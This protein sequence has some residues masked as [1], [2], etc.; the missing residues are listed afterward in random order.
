[1]TGVQALDMGIKYLFLEWA[2]GTGKSTILGW[3]VK[4]AARQLPR[5]T[6]VL[7]GQTY[8]QM[9]A[10]TLPSTKEGL[11]MFG[12]HEGI[13]YVVGRH[14]KKLGFEMPYQA[15][16]KWDNVIHF[17]NGFILVLVSLDNPNSGRGLNSYIV[18]GDEA[19]LLDPE[20]LFNNVQTTNRASK[21]W[22]EKSKLLNAEIFATSTPMTK[23]GK[24]FTS[25]EKKIL[26]AIKGISNEITNPSQ[27]AFIKANA[28][29]NSMNLTKG[30]FKRMKLNSPSISHYN[31]EILNIR[32]KFVLE[33]FYPQLSAEKHYYENFNNNYLES[34]GVKAHKSS[35]NCKQD[36]DL[37][38]NKP[39]IIELDWGVFNSM[40]VSQDDGKD[41]NFLKSF[42]VKNPKIIDDLIDQ[43]FA[44]YYSSH[45]K[46]VIHLYYDRNGNNRQANSKITM[47][48]QAI[49]AF[50]R[51]GWKVIVKTPRTVDPPHNEK[52]V[53]VNYLLRYGGTKGLPNIRINMHNAHDLTV[54]LED[55]PAKEGSK[56]I[57][58]DKSSERSKVIPQEHATHL[59]DA[60]DLA[61]YW[62]YKDKVMRLINNNTERWSVP[63][64]GSAR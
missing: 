9:L 29:A 11:E 10:R 56:G 37:R 12:F 55:A 45:S 46:K 36:A 47:A 60:F 16:S 27:Y 58:K 13:D 23:R 51:N 63:L 34:V 21:I 24:W 28:F 53:V 15:P 44:P 5:A 18:I 49:A 4:E 31:A 20:R 52:F 32:P 17:R 57:Q 40:V 42:W 50:K 14:G 6:G 62:R 30:W 35:F 39:L 19:A 54:S 64:F 22:F 41:W 25:Y 8:M 3:V 26:D 59:S 38:R 7:V 1:M 33:S 61:I 43:D 48:E 2:R